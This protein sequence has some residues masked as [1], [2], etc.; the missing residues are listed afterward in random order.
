VIPSAGNQPY[1]TRIVDA[2]GNPL[3]GLYGL[4]LG[5]TILGT[6]N[7]GDQDLEMGVIFQVNK[8]YAGNT[9][10]RIYV[11]PGN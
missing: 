6:G 7:P 4:N 9:Y 11:D 10:A 5:F 1:T 2:A 8:V 3:P